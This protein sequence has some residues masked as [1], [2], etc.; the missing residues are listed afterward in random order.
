MGAIVHFPFQ[1]SHSCG[2][3]HVMGDGRTGF[4]IGHESAFGSSWG[5]FAGPFARVGDAIAAAHALNRN[6]YGGL[7]E[8]CAG[9]T[10]QGEV[11]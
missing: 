4:E 3:I 11:Q 7:C 1:R 9:D 6:T 5:S 10:V 2:T 8:I